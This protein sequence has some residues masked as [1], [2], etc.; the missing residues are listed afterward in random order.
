MNQQ[1]HDSDREVTALAGG[2]PG[3]LIITTKAP[4]VISGSQAQPLG[5][6]VNTCPACRQHPA[7][8]GFVCQWCQFDARR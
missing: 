3:N 7:Q 8:P 6:P 4:I 2:V 5:A 1:I